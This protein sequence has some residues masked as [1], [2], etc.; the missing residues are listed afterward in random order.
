MDYHITNIKVSLKVNLLCLSSVQNILKR[1]NIS[2]SRYTNF[3][4]IRY[5]F[6]YIIFKTG[7]QNNNHINVTKIKNEAEIKTSISVLQDLLSAE[8]I[9]VQKVNVDNITASLNLQK[10]INLLQ[11][12]QHFQTSS[13]SYNPE[14]FPGLFV[15]FNVGTAI[16]FH[17][18]KC[19]LIGTKTIAD[20]ECLVLKLAV[21]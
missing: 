6:T 7:K 16:I 12:P 18:G 20:I 10:P 2:Y 4:V 3:L 19:I 1:K 14:K 11:L 9:L 17:T 15:K 8:N 13:I 21:I 5:T